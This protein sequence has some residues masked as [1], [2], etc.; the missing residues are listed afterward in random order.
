MGI[1]TLINV[2]STRITMA[3]TRT[4]CKAILIGLGGI[5]G[6]IFCGN[7]WV[8]SV[9]SAAMYKTHHEIP[10]N[11]YALV[12]GTS[13]KTRDGM[14]NPFFDGRIKASAQLYEHQKAH[15]LLLSGSHDRQYYNEP[16]AMKASLLKLKVPSAAIFLDTKGDN[17]LAAIK[18][19]KN[20]WN[21]NQITIVTQQIYAYRALY[22]SQC[23]DLQAV[24]FIADGNTHFFS[25][26]WLREILARIKALIDLHILRKHQ[27]NPDLNVAINR[28]SKQ[29]IT[30]T[31]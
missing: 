25:R 1:S 3:Y 9:P 18:N 6:A 22:I 30:F 31:L 7:V 10:S 14:S 11:Q 2:L 13:P 20:H 19:V 5:G 29:Y 4:I 8:I 28:F 27:D 23:C 26:A 15:F 12:L 17:T 24:I 16:L 21:I